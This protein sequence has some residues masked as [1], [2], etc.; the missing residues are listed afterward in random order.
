M[1]EFDDLDPTEPATDED[2]AAVAPFAALLADESTWAE[3][4]AGLADDLLAVIRTE[5]A[6]PTERPTTTTAAPSEV[7]ATETGARV[8][9]LA[10]RR[11][12]WPRRVLAA[13]A[14]VVAVVVGVTAFSSRTGESS[15]AV[16]LAGTELAPEASATAELVETPDGTLLRLDISDLPPAGPDEYYEAWLRQ[17][18]EVGVSAGTFHFRGGGGEAIG[19]W[20][21]VSPDDYPLITVTIQD[22]DGGAESSGRVV[23]KGTLSP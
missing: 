12:A 11:R 2:L 17:D 16:E 22:L 7:G 5:A 21:A 3:P 14:A 18:P 20:A 15:R 10:S 4:P 6:S 8:I 23:L 19:L 9:D 13:A 1:T